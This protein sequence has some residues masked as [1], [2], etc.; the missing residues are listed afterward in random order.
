MAIEAI[1]MSK[2]RAA[3]AAEFPLLEGSQKSFGETYSFLLGSGTQY[4]LIVDLY[5][6]TL[7]QWTDFHDLLG[8]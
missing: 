3:E 7:G 2:K 6:V 5:S 4:G 8:A 1:I